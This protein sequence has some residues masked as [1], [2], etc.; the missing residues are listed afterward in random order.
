M[1]TQ[2]SIAF[3]IDQAKSILSFFGKVSMI[4]QIA[5]ALVEIA[6]QLTVE[7][8]QSKGGWKAWAMSEL[9][10]CIQ[11]IRSLN[12][13]EPSPEMDSAIA[14]AG[15]IE[16][17]AQSVFI[18]LTVIIKD[19]AAFIENATRFSAKADLWM[20][21]VGDRAVRFAISSVDSACSLSTAGVRLIA[22]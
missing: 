22:G 14:V 7:H 6:R 17:I 4:F 13:Q 5:I 16:A 20:F 3:K 15:A 21:L 12:I 8:V 1:T 19:L 2:L 11:V 18:E 9:E 10:P